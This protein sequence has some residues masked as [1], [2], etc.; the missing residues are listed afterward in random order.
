M[1]KVYLYLFLVLSIFMTS[2]QLA[3][4]VDTADTANTADTA[5]TAGTA[6]T[7]DAKDEK[8]DATIVVTA[9]K[10]KANAKT[11]GS[12]FTIITSEEI[13]KKQARTAI[14]VLRSAPSV[15][16]VQTGGPGGSA[17]IFIRG[18]KNEHTLVLVDGIEV[19]DPTSVG[20]NFNF[21]HILAS[22]IE[23]IEIIR[24]P[25][26]TVYGSDAMGGVINIITKR[27]KGAP[28]MSATVEGGSYD[29]SSATASARGRTGSIN[30]SITATR[31]VTDGISSANEKDG[32]IESDGY[33][34][35]S[36]GL[37]VGFDPTDAL[38]FNLTLKYID[39]NGDI[40]A[41][42]GVG[43]DDP[44]FTMETKE[45]FAKGDICLLLFD[46]RFESRLSYSTATFDRGY[47]DA[48]DDAHPQDSSKN[49][50]N[51]STT[52][53]EYQGNLYL[54]DWN[55]LTLGVESETDKAESVYESE[56]SYGPFSSVFDNKE[57]SNIGYYIQ[58]QIN[59]LGSL[60]LTLGSR[61]DSNSE[62]GTH[63]TYRATVAYLVDAIGITI[64]GSYGTGFKA[65]SLFQ[66]YSQYGDENLS[67]ETSLG[68][69]IGVEK[70][71]DHRNATI[72]VAYF[73]N[74]FKDLI[75]YD[76]GDS[77]YKNIGEAETNGLEIYGQIDLL[78][79][80]QARV[81]YNKT[82]TKDRQTEEALLRRPKDKISVDM[83]YAF[84][85]GANATVSYLRVGERE[86]NDY[87]TYPSVRKQ[88]DS[89]SIVNLAASYAVNNSIKVFGK[90]ENLGDAEYEE[91]LGYGTAGRSYYAGI[92]VVLK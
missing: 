36:A 74:E 40:D 81:A 57:L 65:P 21:A 10:T 7:A 23:R 43:G 67:P 41:G 34:N 26:S 49:T 6:D 42:G 80:L 3:G 62:F 85:P 69:D 22:D 32:A 48:T 88:M 31:Y 18:A 51:G 1:N 9:T 89:Y 75:D 38:S 87:S 29:T 47:F 71:Y 15:D 8:S 37:N 4:A 58:E 24:G 70:K 12:A 2:P 30:Y 28:V 84:L 52:K 13:E 11:V 44:N 66:L 91:V 86:A 50:F 77:K 92:N 64:K 16:V 61:V 56:S 78:D 19:N 83:N 90:V 17:A 73:F 54:A 27:G 20:R 5:D 45:L 33:N 68:W 53:I 79:N 14:D 63:T 76:F 35:T 55:T 72:G 39:A 46:D 82:D 59:P 60:F 25:Q